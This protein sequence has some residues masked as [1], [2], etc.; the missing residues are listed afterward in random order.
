MRT[1]LGLVIGTNVQAWDRDLDTWAAITRAS[2]F[3]AFVA[4]SSSANLRAL[5]TDETGTGSA[6]FANSPTLV[7]P[8][9]GAATATSMAVSG[10]TTNN[11]TGGPA[12]NNI[13]AQ[14][15]GNNA[16]MVFASVG[17]PKWEIGEDGSDNFFYYDDV[18]ART[19]MSIV[20]GGDMTLMPASGKVIAGGALVSQGATGGVGYATGAGGTVTQATSKSTGVTL[21][22]VSG[23]VTMNN[24]AL[25][26]GAKVPFVVSNSAVAATD[27]I[28]ANVASG[29][30]P[31]AYRAA[32]TT[33]AAGSFTLTVE[34]ITAGSLSE[35]PTINFSV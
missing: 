34:N 14:T 23:Q 29:G 6:V 18:G 21:N 28:L 3:D 30:T 8:S 26:A 27:T 22:K 17:L 4:T 16:S 2:G 11:T 31:N 7:T 19:V 12:N 15:A 33:V 5:L 9:L 13:N 24:A 32:V 1:L 25:A 35:T 10:A 20:A